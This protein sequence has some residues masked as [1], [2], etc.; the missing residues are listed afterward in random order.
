MREQ[1][2]YI[3]ASQH[4]D[5]LVWLV[6][7]HGVYTTWKTS[8]ADFIEVAKNE[9][10]I[11]AVA[12]DGFNPDEPNVDAV[13]VIDEAKQL[14]EYLVGKFDGKVDIILGESLGGMVMTEV[15]LDSRICIH[16]AIADG[17]T[18]IEYPNFKSDFPKRMIS[19][20]IAGVMGAVFKMNKATLAKIVGLKDD[21]ELDKMLYSNVSKQTMYN[22]EY[23]MFGYRYKYEAFNLSDTY[24][25]HGEKEPGLKKVLKLPRDKYHFQHKIF[26]GLGHGSLLLEPEK[27]LEEVNLAYAGYKA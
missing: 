16:T 9:Y 20:A 22:M 25:L 18:I 13:S 21:A 27:L 17:F 6:L 26:P 12:Y 24:L 10:H 3:V 4:T 19:S 1:Q 5:R 15:L 11:I 23:Y 7:L 2:A 14:T 8:F